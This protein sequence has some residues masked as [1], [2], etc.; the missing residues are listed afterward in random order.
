MH[1]AA[2]AI[3]EILESQT[4]DMVEAFGVLQIVW[5]AWEKAHGVVCGESKLTD[6]T[7]GEA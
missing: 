5:S 2:S 4:P 1:R 6:A 7:K 3:N